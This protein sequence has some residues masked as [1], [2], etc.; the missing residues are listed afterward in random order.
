MENNNLIEEIKQKI[1]SYLVLSSKD[2]K[3]LNELLQPSL[4]LARCNGI[5]DSLINL[6]LDKPSFMS[7][8]CYQLYKVDEGLSLKIEQSLTSEEK[9]MV[10]TFKLIKD[11]NKIT[12]SDEADDIRNMFLAISKDVRVVL[13]KLAGIL[14]DISK[15]NPPLDNDD[16]RFVSQ[17]REIH[18]PL[19]ERLGLDYLKLGMDDNV[20]R[21]EHTE[22]YNALKQTLDLKKS[23]NDAQLELTKSKIFEALQELNIKGEIYTR[24]KHIS[25]IF[26]KLHNKNLS[27]DQIYDLV[28]MRVI[29]ETVEECYSVLGKIHS[30]Y[31]PMPGRFKDYIAYPKPNG[32][33]SLHTTVIVEN[34]HP[35]EIQIRTEAMH[36]ENEFGATAHWLYK[37]KKDKKTEF[38]KRITWFREMIDE[39]KDLSSEDFVETLKSDLY[40]G[41]IFVQTPKGR[42]I[43]FPDG[44]TAIDF[45][46]AIHSDIGNSCIGIK[47]NGAMKPITTQLKNGDI[48]EVITSSHS[49]GPSR[50]WLSFAKTNGAR[51]KIRAF[52]KTE[53]KE[54]NIKH[55]KVMLDELAKARDLDTSKLFTEEYISVVL[56]RY[57]MKDITELYAS[58]G[59]GSLT[60]SQVL[61]KFTT[62]YNKDN[63]PTPKPQQIVNIKTSK[64]GVLIDG[65]S[66]MLIRFAGC[67]NPIDGD[68]ILGYISRGKGV[69]I[70]RCNCPNV[71]NLE[72]ER[73]IRAQWS[74]KD[75]SSFVASI[76]IVADKK[77]GNLAKFTTVITNVKVT[78]TGFEAREI[79]DTFHAVIAVKVKNRDE[80][81]KVINLISGI[82]GVRDVK[83][84]EGWK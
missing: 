65:D 16:K 9:K 49:K 30:M 28:A 32:Y 78:I 22:E 23:E 54:E 77:D 10:E 70:H 3:I 80:L 6:K 44:A 81:N 71:A 82:K 37:E 75:D 42:V 12:Q 59:S 43:E 84:S 18:V 24:Q 4:N 51:N 66:G 26:K 5:I 31:R 40:G 15:L 25:S 38:D 62:L 53:L 72:E 7:F 83:R 64:D 2:N 45:A 14:Y 68:D 34:Q 46:Y 47:V 52:F 50:D 8:L 39:S 11:I 61:G 41:V 79:G 13:I 58:L 69:T 20:I 76:R 33:K 17:V 19:S 56:E 27:F 21:L 74:A 67:C 55:G 57:K 29:V 63:S 60:T 48:V 36:K 35:M 73:I 1:T